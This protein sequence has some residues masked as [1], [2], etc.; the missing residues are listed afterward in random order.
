MFQTKLTYGM[1]CYIKHKPTFNLWENKFQTK[2]TYGM[3]CYEIASVGKE[4]FE[5]VS[6]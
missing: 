2:L 6:N 4:A 3:I 1:I 5:T